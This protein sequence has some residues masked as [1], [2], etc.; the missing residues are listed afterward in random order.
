MTRFSPAEPAKRSRARIDSHQA[1]WIDKAP[2]EDMRNL[3][4]GFQEIIDQAER[5]DN[6]P[7][8]HIRRSPTR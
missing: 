8:D 2:S 5:I 3:M 4:T 7:S 1:H 6:P